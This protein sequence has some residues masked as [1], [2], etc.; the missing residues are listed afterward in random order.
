[1]KKTRVQHLPTQSL[2]EPQNAARWSFADS[3]V[4]T[5]RTQTPTDAGFD[6]GNVAN[7]IIQL[8]RSI[9]PTLNQSVLLTFL[10]QRVQDGEDPD[11]A[12]SKLLAELEALNVIAQEE[13]VELEDLLADLGCEGNCSLLRCIKHGQQARIEKLEQRHRAVMLESKL[14]QNDLDGVYNGAWTD[15]VKTTPTDG[16]T[17][18]EQ[19]R[20]STPLVRPSTPKQTS[21]APASR[22]HAE[23]CRQMA[24]EANQRRIHFLQRAAEV[25]GN[26]KVGFGK[27]EHGALGGSLEY[28]RQEARKYEQTAARWNQQAFESIKALNIGNDAVDLHYFTVKEALVLLEEKLDEF[29]ASRATKLRVITGKGSHSEHREARI[30]PAVIKMLNRRG[31]PHTIDSG[32][33]TVKKFM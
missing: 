3:S 12:L 19:Y 26:G 15:V 17:I 6:A 7:N 8:L 20:P 10:G 4:E 22:D 33:V 23:Y 29:E 31:L 18:R 14:L 2:G 9:Y 13:D 24:R 5:L 1:M 30:K 27:T 11:Q 21:L 32:S 16:W 25:W 28:F